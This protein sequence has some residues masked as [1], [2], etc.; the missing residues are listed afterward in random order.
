[1]ELIQS[2]F[3]QIQLL[4]KTS[5]I[6]A[7][8]ISLWG[9]TVLTW[10]LRDIPRK[11]GSFFLNQFTTTLT[12]NNSGYEGNSHQ[13]N[14][15]MNW[16][17]A[18]RW[19]RWS[20][21]LSLDGRGWDGETVVVGP[22]FGSH[23]FFYRGHFF[24]F[25]KRR[26]ESSGSE[27]EKQEM[28]IRVLGRNRQAILNLI[29]DFRHKPDSSKIGIYVFKD[30]WRWLTEIPKRPLNTVIIDK[31]LKA[32]LLKNLDSFFAGREWYTSKGM[33]YKQTY[34][35]HGRPG[36]GKTSLLKAL[37]SYYGKSIC[38]LNIAGMTD[39]AFELAL[40]SA[41]KNCF[42]IIEDFDS[43]RATKSRTPTM[44]KL[45]RAKPGDKNVLG[46]AEE[47]PKESFNLADLDFEMLSLTK[48][49]NTLDGVVSLD[50]TVIFMTTNHLDQI[51]EALTRKGRVDYTYEVPYLGHAEILEYLWL[52]FPD[53]HLRFSSVEAEFLPIAGCDLQAL[54]LEHRDDAEAFVN[55][56][57][58][59][60]NKRQLSQTD[61]Q[62]LAV[63]GTGTPA[64]Q[65]E[66]RSVLAQHLQV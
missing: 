63:M 53:F 15:F 54:F 62:I 37:A 3:D 19:S 42:I 47:K 23:F 57:P 20:R 35:L 29:E 30:E 60:L 55:A 48:I 32:D 11:V 46:T 18:S 49:L 36:T 21:Y 52:M 44:P 34:I 4:A 58:H 22:G 13:F 33:P 51:D 41:P 14:G 39:S 50:E 28:K 66:A 43:A 38:T 8:A 2:L 24:W 25:E 45:E 40:Q 10:A 56:I 26:L 6:I 7:G 59:R 61:L 17:T 65:E 5:P 16:F 12:M 27:K 31:K 1:M 9:L 64:Q